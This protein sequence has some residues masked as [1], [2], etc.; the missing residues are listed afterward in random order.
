[1]EPT[2]VAQVLT[3]TFADV[4]RLIDPVATIDVLADGFKALTAGKVQAPPRPLVSVPG[5]GVSLA[6]MAWM[7]GQLMSLKT[8]NVFHHNHEQGLPSHV[9]V[10]QLFDPENGVP[11]AIMDGAVITGVRTAAGAMLT[12][13][14]LARKD[15]RI[16]TV[17]GGG[18]Q[19]RDHIRLLGAV[20]SLEEIRVVSRTREGAERAAK[21]IARTRVV[22]DIADAVRASDIVCLTTSSDTPAIESGWVKPGTHITS[23]GFAPPGGELPRDLI[24]R[25]TVY[26]EARTAFSPAP[27]GCPELQGLDPASGIEIGELLTGTRPGRTSAEQITIY[28]SMGNAMEDMVTANVVYRTAK[29]Q[30]AGKLIEL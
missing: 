7:P 20:R 14:E 22:T 18:V 16:A 6:M 24:P 3:L 8:V 25:A 23:V 5:K 28:K 2:Q 29:Q 17:V 15:A 11:V 26:V 30:G 1:L 10:I 13:R 21:G 12:V 4:E 27:V 19:A 9:A